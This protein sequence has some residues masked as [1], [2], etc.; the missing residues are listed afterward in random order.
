MTI[1][2]FNT[3]Y[4]RGN[5]NGRPKKSLSGFIFRL[6]WFVC[7]LFVFLWECIKANV[8]VAF[9]VLHPDLPIRPATIKAKTSLKSEIGLTFL[10]NS[11]TLTPGRTTIDIDK[12]KGYIYL[13][14]LNLKHGKEDHLTVLGRY[15][16]ILRRIFE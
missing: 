5:G 1:D 10:A 4:S 16:N 11:L 15:E 2:V 8:D 7:Y 13:H 12:D 9:R 14:I 3:A 6:S